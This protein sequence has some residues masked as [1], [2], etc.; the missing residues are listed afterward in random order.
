[1]TATNAV[2]TS[3]AKNVTVTCNDAPIMPIYEY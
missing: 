2:G 3:A 1:V